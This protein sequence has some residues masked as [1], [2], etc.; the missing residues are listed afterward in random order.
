MCF[1]WVS[2]VGFGVGGYTQPG[3]FSIVVVMTYVCWSDMLVVL[4]IA[5]CVLPKD[6]IYRQSLLIHL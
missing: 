4:E 6:R 3:Y 1:V 2:F 5:S